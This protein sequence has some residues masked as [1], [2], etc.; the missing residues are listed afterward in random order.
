MFNFLKYLLI[1]ILVGLLFKFMPNLGMNDHQVLTSLLLVLIVIIVVDLLFGV[2]EGLQNVTPIQNYNGPFVFADPEPVSST[3]E[4]EM[5]LHQRFDFDLAEPAM[6]Q[7]GEVNEDLSGRQIDG[8]IPA[9]AIPSLICESKINSF[10]RQNNFM[11][12]SQ[13]TNDGNVSYAGHDAEDV[14]RVHWQ[15]FY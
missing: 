13:V 10:I 15:Q 7:D 3:F 12:P 2:T 14:N 1:A 4:D 9:D 11:R 5:H 6:I 8:T